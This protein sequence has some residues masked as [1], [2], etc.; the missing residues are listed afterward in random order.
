MGS[1]DESQGTPAPETRTSTPMD[2][3][4]HAINGRQW[5]RQR[6]W[7][8]TAMSTPTDTNRHVN[9]N[10]CQKPRQRQWTTATPSTDVNGHV[11][12]NGRQQPRQRQRTPTATSTPM[13]ANGHVNASSHVNANG[14]MATS[15]T[16]GSAAECSPLGGFFAKRQNRYVFC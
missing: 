8:P 15:P 4:G 14:P 9:A 2:A 13:D 10:G 11:N 5:P 12:A 7:T 16:D 3:D 1:N 6:Q